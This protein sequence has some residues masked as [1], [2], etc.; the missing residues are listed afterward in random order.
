MSHIYNPNTKMVRVTNRTSKPIEIMVD[1][2]ARRFEPGDCDENFC[3]TYVAQKAVE[4]S[5]AAGTEDPGDF[6]SGE[7]KLG[8]KAWG[9][10][11]SPFEEDPN[12]IERFDRSL[13]PKDRQ[14]VARGIPAG[15]Q[16]RVDAEMGKG[17]GRGLR[18]IATP[19]VQGPGGEN[20][21][22]VSFSDPEG[23]GRG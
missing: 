11:V 10:D 6:Y 7:H 19:A 20:L 1:G 3:E 17:A 9:H 12:A 15:L 22:N 2:H 18:G 13:L 21:G 5:I 23:A 8:V 14:V 4:R 16:G